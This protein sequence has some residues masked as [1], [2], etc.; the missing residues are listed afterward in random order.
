M[1]GNDLKAL[2]AEVTGWIGEIHPDR[3]PMNTA[4]KLSEE[5]AELIHALYTGDGSVAEECAD[6]LILLLD[7]AYLYDIDLEKSF[8]RKMA[9]NR[10]RRW[11]KV[12]GALKHASA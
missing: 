10:G 8:L 1:A 4:I 3:D 5:T 2:T 7:V 6:I 9:I 12:K 11:E